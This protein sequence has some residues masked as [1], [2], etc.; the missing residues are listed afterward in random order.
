MAPRTRA[1]VDLI[2]HQVAIMLVLVLIWFGGEIFWQNFE[3]GFRTSSAWAPVQWPAKMMI[4]LAGILLGI[5]LIA[6]LI[7]FAVIVVRG[8]ELESR[9][10]AKEHAH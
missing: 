10:A 8:V 9:Y 2:T 1:V 4:P 5:Q 3:F 6:N 7:R